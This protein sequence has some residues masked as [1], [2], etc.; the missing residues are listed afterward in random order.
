MPQPSLHPWQPWLAPDPAADDVTVPSR[1]LFK[2][3]QPWLLL[4]ATPRLAR[5]ALTIYPAQSLK[6]RLAKAALGCSLQLGL[7]PGTQPVSL[8]LSPRSPFVEFLQTTAG[9]KNVPLLAAL[10][11]NPAAPGQRQVFLLF[12]DAGASQAVVKTG[13]GGP[14]AE[15]IRA[16][17]T[18]LRSLPAGTPGAPQV[19]AE[20]A[21]YDLRAFALDFCAGDSPSAAD[22]VAPQQLL[23]A[24]LQPQREARVMELPAMM[25]LASVGANDPWFAPLR[26]E[27]VRPAV[28]HGDFAPWNVKVSPRDGSW[29]ALDWERGEREGVPAWDW[30]HFVIQPALLVHR[31]APETIADRLR[32]FL[33]SAP[34]QTYATAARITGLENA[35]LAAYLAHAARVIRP[36]EGLAGTEQL[37][38]IITRKT[39]S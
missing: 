18:A 32:T 23:T 12:D 2:R 35:L 14:A 31:L 3:G 13:R 28:M 33:A 20:F 26:A 5:Q 19:R 1:V 4:P 10:A 36:S 7:F 38:A 24:W 37:L 39:S 11:G 30:F 15:L 17:V 29:T 16:E 6:A 27:V 8:R 22:I 25:R 34:F 21:R 9:T